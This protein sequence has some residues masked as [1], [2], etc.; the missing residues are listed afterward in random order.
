M[1]HKEG[2]WFFLLFEAFFLFFVA[3][4]FFTLGSDFPSSQV[5]GRIG[6]A[7]ILFLWFI[8]LSRIRWEKDFILTLPALLFF[9]FIAFELIRAV[10]GLWQTHL[11]FVSAP[12]T[13]SFYFGLFILSFSFFKSKTQMKR[14]SWILS[15]SGFILAMNAIPALLVKGRMGYVDQYGQ[16]GFFYPIFYFHEAIPKYLLSRFAHANYTGDVIA[17]GFFAALGLLFYS[18]KRIAEKNDD[19]HKHQKI[20]ATSLGLPATFA[21]ATALAVILLFSRGTIVSFSIAFLLFLLIVTI[22]FPSRTQ[23]ILAAAVFLL[24]TSFLFWGANMK[25]VWKEIQTLKEEWNSTGGATSFALNREG[26]RRAIAIHRTFPVWGVG[27]DGYAGVSERFASPGTQT[28]DWALSKFR[29]MCH[30]LQ[31][32][33]EEG[34]GAYLYFLFL[35]SYFLAMA[36]KLLKTKSRFKFIAGLS[37]SMSVFMVCVHASFNHLMQQVSI[38]SLIYVL[39]GASLAVLQKEFEHD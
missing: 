11:Q 14:F 28:K 23:L 13:W 20:R 7:V 2:Q 24:V 21:I 17:I 12:L 33:A 30:Y 25:N 18:L 15:W 35:L 5:Y 36:W 27:T 4:L 34:I 10:W 8:W 32:L 19:P 22:K 37:L 16:G 39:M 6:F 38:S 31:L 3:S 29:V 9:S 26:A 1:I